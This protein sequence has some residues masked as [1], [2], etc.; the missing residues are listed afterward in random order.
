M[1]L[2][3]VWLSC[4]GYASPYTA[5]ICASTSRNQRWPSANYDSPG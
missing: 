1:P 5:G 4:T 2:K 3:D